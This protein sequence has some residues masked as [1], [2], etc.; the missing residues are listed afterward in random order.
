MRNSRTSWRRPPSPSGTRTHAV[1]WALWTS[2]IAQRSIKRFIVAP[3]ESDGRTTARESLMLWSLNRVLKA[4]VRGA[5]DSRVS[6]ISGLGGTSLSRRR[7]G[8]P[9]HFHPF[10]VRPARAHEA[11]ICEGWLPHDGASLRRGRGLEAS[12]P[13][14]AGAHSAIAGPV[15]RCAGRHPHP[16]RDGDRVQ[17]GCW[18]ISQ[19]KHASSRAT[20]TATVVRFFARAASRCA[21]RRCSRSCARH[22]ASIA[23]GG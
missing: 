2:S 14:G 3:S 11:L 23:A 9:R 7:P 21:Q 20:A 19:T 22:A 8:G 15:W 10:R 13:A 4:T 18:A 1:T 5:R 16:E 12:A 6:L 17:S